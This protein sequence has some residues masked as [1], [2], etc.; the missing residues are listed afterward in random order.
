MTNLFLKPS[1]P[2]L[3][4][5][6]RIIPVSK[7]YSVLIQNIIK[8]MHAVAGFEQGDQ[9]K[10]IMVGLAAPQ[11]GI[12]KRII[13]VDVKANGR[14]RVGDLRVY[15]NP[16]II[17]CSKQKGEWYEGCYS[18]GKIC[19]IVS[20]PTSIKIRAYILG[21]M[22]NQPLGFEAVEEEYSGYVARIFQHEIDHL[23]G[24]RF[25]DL[26]K[27]PDNLH[28]VNKNE[29]KLYRN[30]QAWRNWPKKCSFEKWQKIQKP[31]DTISFT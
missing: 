31:Q 6:S 20:R 30:K 17:W 7:I 18:T 12:L 11:I 9:K 24:I 2:N 10:P 19:G 25:P 1:D 16:E 23:N 8:K 28:W 22:P 29:F 21:F 26:V 15:I 3:T 4:K 27:N 5:L 14:G 13:L